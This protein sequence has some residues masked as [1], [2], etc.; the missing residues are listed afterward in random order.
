MT[1]FDEETKKKILVAIRK[2]APY[3]IACN[4][5]NLDYRNFRRWIV[6]GKK[7]KDEGKNTPFSQFRQEVKEAEG[8]TA[9]IWLDKIDA[10][11]NKGA[12]QA[13]A[14]KLERRY[15]EYFA[16]DPTQLLEVKKLIKLLSKGE[17]K[18]GEVND[19]EEKEIT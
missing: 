13:A 9:L 3:V 18:D 2:G 5:A 14:W 10:A 11:M 4:Y 17:P 12:W 6:R 7:D 8:T 19:S 15:R 1:K 16:T